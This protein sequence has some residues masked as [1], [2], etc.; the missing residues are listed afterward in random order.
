MN[1]QVGKKKLNLRAAHRRA[2]IRNQTI[3]FINFGFLQTTKVRAKVVQQFAE[4][5][6]TVARKGNEFNII[7]RVKQ[8]I[9]YSDKAAKKLI[10]EIAP[11]Y[12]ER[13]GGYTRIIPLGKR[14]SDTATIARL[15]WV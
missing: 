1:H 5:L 12:V 2:L 6:V 8:L 3:H 10:Q 4:K 13:N 15:E 9:P 11:K 14:I 7:R